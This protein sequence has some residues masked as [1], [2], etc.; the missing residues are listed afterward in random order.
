MCVSICVYTSVHTHTH[1]CNHL[2]KQMPWMSLSF[3]TLWLQLIGFHDAQASSLVALFTLGCAGGSLVGGYLGAQGCFAFTQPHVCM[4]PT[5]FTTMCIH[6]NH[7]H[8]QQPSPAISYTPS[9]QPSTSSQQ[10]PPHNNISTLHQPGDRMSQSHPN[11]GRIL[12]NQLSVLL[13]LPVSVVLLKGLPWPLLLQGASLQWR[14]SCVLVLFGL[15]ASWYVPATP[16]S[17]GT[18]TTQVWLQQ[19]GHVCGYR[20]RAHAQQGVCL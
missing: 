17:Q 19:F 18:P 2:C 1:M 4:L 7:V 20:A 12:T 16:I 3:L 11:S 13:G 10:Q 5:L 8:P 15:V 14:Y 9:Q 6:N